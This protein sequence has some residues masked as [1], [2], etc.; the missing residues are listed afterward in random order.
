MYTA[1]CSWFGHA[2]IV[3]VG[4]CCSVLSAILVAQPSTR[5]VTLPKGTYLQLTIAQTVSTRFSQEG[6]RFTATLE[7]PV[8]VDGQTVLAKGT[9]VV[10]TV[11]R[12]KRPGRFRGK[13]ELFLSFDYIHLADG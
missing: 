2:R 7:K 8:L 11:S 1:A 10:G 6:E 3:A 13:A 4:L 5:P 9:Q 12:V